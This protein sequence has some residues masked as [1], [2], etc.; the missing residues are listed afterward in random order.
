MLSFLRQA[1]L[2]RRQ[3][4]RRYLHLPRALQVL[5]TRR[6][7][8]PHGARYLLLPRY[9]SVER[10]QSASKLM[11]AV[12]GILAY[13]LFADRQKYNDYTAISDTPAN[14]A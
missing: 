7:Q 3:A 13:F 11:L 10:L 14:G 4:P 9:V 5:S 8:T 6:A 2:T 12:I 1:R